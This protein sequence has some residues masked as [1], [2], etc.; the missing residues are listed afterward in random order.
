MVTGAE[1]GAVS[2]QRSCPGTVHAS[3]TCVVCGTVCCVLVQ[4]P[5]R[6]HFDVA[7]CMPTPTHPLIQAAYM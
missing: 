6:M 1:L 4:V 3:L 7:R 5:E 2:I